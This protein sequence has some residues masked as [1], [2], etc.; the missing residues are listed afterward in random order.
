VDRLR[1]IERGHHSRLINLLGNTR[2]D[3]L[4]YRAQRIAVRQNPIAAGRT[5][6][7]STRWSRTSGIRAGRRAEGSRDVLRICEIPGVCGDRPP[8]IASAVF[9]PGAEEAIQTLAL[10]VSL[11]GVKCSCSR[12]W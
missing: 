6:Q 11:N 5:P 2:P 10:M 7:Q 4:R 3:I 9:D 12:C 8:A 1:W